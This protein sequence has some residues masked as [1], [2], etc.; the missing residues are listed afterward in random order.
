MRKSTIIARCLVNSKMIT[1]PEQAE[2]A[3]QRVFAEEFPGRDFSLWNTSVNEEWGAEMIRNVGVA[4]TI[5]VK[6]FIK[7]LD[8]A[9]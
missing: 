4:T 3:V 9:L 8:S 5:N 1:S 2:L 7:D 6:N